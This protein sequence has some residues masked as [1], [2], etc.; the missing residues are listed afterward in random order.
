MVE[1]GG[2][3]VN[4]EG[5]EGKKF[6]KKIGEELASTCASIH[7]AQPFAKKLHGGKALRNDYP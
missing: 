6:T 2:R 1:H 7:F 5:G 3:E 4:E